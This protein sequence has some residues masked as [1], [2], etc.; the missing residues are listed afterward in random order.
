VAVTFRAPEGRASGRFAGGVNTAVTN[1]SG[2]AT[3]AIFTANNNVGGPY[4]VTASVAGIAAPAIFLLTNTAGVP[5]KL[6]AY[7]RRGQAAERSREHSL[8]V[9]AASDRDGR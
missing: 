4:T 3:S 2:M 6:E 1:A 8:C 5:S 7:G 9:W